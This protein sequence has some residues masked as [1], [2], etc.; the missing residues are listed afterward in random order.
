VEHAYIEPEVALAYWEGE[1]L[2]IHTPTQAAHY[3]RLEIARMLNLPVSKVRVI[4]ATT[5][6]GFGGKIELSLQH[7][8]ALGAYITGRPV[9]MVWTREESFIASIKR[10]AFFMDFH[11]G[12]TKDGRLIAAKVQIIANTGA[13]AALGP[14][15]ITRS[16]IV[17]IGPYECPNVNVDA[18][19]VYTN[20]QIQGAM[21]GFGVPQVM[22]CHEPILD[23][24]ARRCELSPLA[25]RRLNMLRPG[26]VTLTQQVLEAGVGALETLEKVAAEYT[27][28]RQ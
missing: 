13:Y 20:T 21:R 5:G 8:A 10:H 14:S 6:G 7:F 16:I 22:T 18:Y 2:T 9:K 24:I 11:M 3:K 12:A 15:V 25:I 26:S 17:A 23:E 28:H 27:G 19:G 1:T 4:Q